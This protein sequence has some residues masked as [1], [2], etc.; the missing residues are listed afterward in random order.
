LES[1]PEELKE[2]MVQKPLWG[3]K[4]DFNPN[5]RMWTKKKICLKGNWT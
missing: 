4:K 3:L 5:V 2:Q 1:F